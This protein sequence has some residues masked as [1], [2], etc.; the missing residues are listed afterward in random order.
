MK[1]FTKANKPI[2]SF[3]DYLGIKILLAAIKWKENTCLTYLEYYL[4]EINKRERKRVQKNAIS[5]KEIF[6]EQDYWKAKTE[7]LQ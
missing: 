4:S 5:K 3:Q 6:M 2:R 7:Y 1:I